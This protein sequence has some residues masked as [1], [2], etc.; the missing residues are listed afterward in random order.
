MWQRCMNRKDYIAALLSYFTGSFL[1]AVAKREPS[2]IADLEHCRCKV[3]PSVNPP[4]LEFSLAN[5]FNALWRYARIHGV[6]LPNQSAWDKDFKEFCRQLMFPW[7]TEQFKAAGYQ[8][9]VVHKSNSYA[10]CEYELSA[11]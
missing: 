9:R 4:S 7:P 6:A 5:I 11:T 3:E 8:L 1:E 2:V 10:K